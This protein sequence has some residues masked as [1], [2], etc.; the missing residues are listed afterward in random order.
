MMPFQVNLFQMSFFE[1]FIKIKKKLFLFFALYILFIKRKKKTKKVHV[2]QN[3]SIVWTGLFTFQ[4][5]D[6]AVL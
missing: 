6:C 3:C 4:S 1:I 5:L 2:L